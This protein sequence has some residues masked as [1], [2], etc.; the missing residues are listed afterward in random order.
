MSQAVLEEWTPEALS[1]RLEN[2]DVVILQPKGVSMLPFIRQGIDKVELSRPDRLEVGD[3]VLAFFGGKYILH[4]IYAID[5]EQVTLKGDGNL[6]GIEQGT[7]SDIIGVVTS[8]INPKGKKRKPGKAWLWRHTRRY[9]KY[10]L[11]IY[12]KLNVMAHGH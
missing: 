5:G 10:Q 9:R 6:Y 8:I 7:Q 11:K 4:R 3:I 1:Q 2:G 12:R